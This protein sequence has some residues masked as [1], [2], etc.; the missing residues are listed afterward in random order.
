MNFVVEKSEIHVSRF[1]AVRR[2]SVRDS[3]QRTA[4]NDSWTRLHMQ[5]VGK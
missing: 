3:V 4:R 5:L 1:V 2:N